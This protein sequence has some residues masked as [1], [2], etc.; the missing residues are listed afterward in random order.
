MIL[1]CAVCHI[2]IS[3]DVHELK[4]RGRLS[5]ERG[6]DFLPQGCYLIASAA[7]NFS[8][9]TDGEFILNLKDVHNLQRHSDP[10]RLNGCCGLDGLDGIN[11]VCSNGHEIGTQRTDCWCPHYIHIPPK[12]VG[13]F[14]PAVI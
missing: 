1:R 3:D 6:S 12:N 9:H 5:D 14:E 13:V 8:S 4:D 2:P 11:T 7:D 10:S